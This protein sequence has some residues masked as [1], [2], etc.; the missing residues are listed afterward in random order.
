MIKWTNDCVSCADGC[1]GC[2][3]DKD[4]PVRCCDDCG[5]ERDVDARVFRYNGQDL[6]QDC[7]IEHLVKE[8]LIYEIDESEV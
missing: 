2:G 4:Y 1:H 6:C 5:V 8:G 7:L 3:A